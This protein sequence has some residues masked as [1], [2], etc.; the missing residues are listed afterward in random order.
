MVNFQ[1]KIPGY[2]VNELIYESTKT[3]LF[4]GVRELDQITVAI[5]IL[6]NEY[7]SFV[8]LAQ[9]RHQYTITKHLDLPG[10]IKTYNLENYRNGYALVMEFGGISLKK[11]CLRTKYQEIKITPS[12]KEVLKVAIRIVSIIDGLHQSRVIHKDIKPAN[13]LIN[14]SAGEVKLIDFSIASLIPEGTQTIIN[15]NVLEGTLAYISPEQTG[16][17]NRGIDYRTDFYSLGVTLYELFTK[18]LPFSTDDPT[19]LVHCHIAK[20]PLAASNVNP[21]IPAMI[22]DIIGK[23][24]AKNPEDRYQSALGLKND[25]EICLQQ[26]DR[27]TNLRFELGIRDISDRFV[28]LEK[29]YGRTQEIETLLAA[30]ERVSEGAREVMLVAGFSGIGKTAVVNEAHKMIL[31]QQGYFIKGKFDQLQRDIPLSAIIQALRNLLRQ[32]LSESNEQVEQWKT[33]INLAVGDN[34]QLIIDLIPELELLI[35]KQLDVAE[36]EP[37]TAEN[38]FKL[39]FPKFIRAFTSISHPLVMFLTYNGRT[40]FP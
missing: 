16:R 33:K 36:T 32:I 27:R 39:V 5:K 10:I 13:I 29:L 26:W 38:R 30:V 18:Q 15:P 37:N 23:L 12:L 21:K 7:P 6:R 9:F 35:G 11:W 31:R 4:Q 14:P 19:E 17:M 28:I 40:Q 2:V 25:L 3:L 22:S 20:Q 24:M 8:E 1:I 34:G